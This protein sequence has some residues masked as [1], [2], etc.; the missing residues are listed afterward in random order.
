MKYPVKALL[1]LASVIVAL[2]VLF[3]PSVKVSLGVGH[4]DIPLDLIFLD[5]ASGRP[6]PER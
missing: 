6:S 5:A 1:V 4:V 3:P 2:A